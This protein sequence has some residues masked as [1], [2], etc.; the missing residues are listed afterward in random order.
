MFLGQHCL[1]YHYLISLAVPCEGWL[2]HPTLM[3]TQPDFYIIWFYDAKPV[4]TILCTHLVFDSPSNI[5]KTDS[6]SKTINKGLLSLLNK[7]FTELV[8]QVGIDH[9]ISDCQGAREL[10][11][12]VLS[13]L[14]TA[15]CLLGHTL[16]IQRG[17]SA[18]AIS[19]GMVEIVVLH[20][21]FFSIFNNC[22]GTIFTIESSVFWFGLDFELS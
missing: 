3:E 22:C 8:F 1:G 20:L 12:S 16:F 17:F 4:P 18:L 13:R 21:D 9:Y 11:L 2:E 19:E 15:I 5:P 14:D 10:K 7:W 6:F